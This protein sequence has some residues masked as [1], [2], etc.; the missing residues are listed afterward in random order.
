MISIFLLL[1]FA[2]I[3]ITVLFLAIQIRF[4]GISC[5]SSMIFNQTILGFAL[6][7]IVWLIGIFMAERQHSILI[8]IITIVGYGTALSCYIFYLYLLNFSIK[9]DSKSYK[10]CRAFVLFVLILIPVATIANV[11]IDFFCFTPF[12]KF[13]NSWS[14]L[15]L[16]ILALLVDIISVCRL[17]IFKKTAQKAFSVFDE[18]SAEIDLLTVII[19]NTFF[20]VLFNLLSLVCGLFRIILAADNKNI[21]LLNSFICIFIFCT[22]AILMKLQTELIQPPKKNQVHALLV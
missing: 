9:S 4:H 1:A 13:E 15:V 6:G 14:K 22:I 17:V 8:Q 19:Q 5:I 3:F 7:F 16:G 21:G 11:I 12:V 20:C 10:I 18:V 2:T